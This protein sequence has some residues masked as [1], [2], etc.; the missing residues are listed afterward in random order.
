METGRSLRVGKGATESWSTG[1]SEDLAEWEGVVGFAGILM[2]GGGSLV[3]RGLDATEEKP[4]VG[5]DASNESAGTGW[6][7]A[8]TGGVLGWAT[9]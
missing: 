4:Q 2:L 5:V 1:V 7:A 3:L 8:A 9:K 6:R